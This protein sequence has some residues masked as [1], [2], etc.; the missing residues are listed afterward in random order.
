[1]YR[2]AH[3]LSAIALKGCQKPVCLKD[4]E[5]VPVAAYMQ[6]NHASLL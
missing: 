5:H 2:N 1:M 4:T 3:A 6:L